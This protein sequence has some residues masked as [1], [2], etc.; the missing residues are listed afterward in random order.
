MKLKE[1]LNQLSHL[2][3][4]LD[5]LCYS[6]DENLLAPNHG[7]RLLEIDGIDVVEAE[8]HR[9]EDEI[10]SLKFEKSDLSEVHVLINVTSDF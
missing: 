3:P 9:G 2:D 7:F 5:V 8:K 6:E 10:G 1:L 4:D